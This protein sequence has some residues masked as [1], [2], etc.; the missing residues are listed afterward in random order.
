MNNAGDGD[1]LARGQKSATFAGGFGPGELKPSIAPEEVPSVVD[2]SALFAPKRP[3]VFYRGVP[4]NRRILVTQVELESNSSI[5]IPDS[6]KGHSEV[7]KIKA[8]SD[9]SELR[10][11]GLKVGDLV[12]FDKYAAHGQMFP[13]LNESG[14]TEPTLLLQE[15]DIQM[16]MEAV[17]N[18]PEPIVN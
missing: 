10:T 1:R 5:I 14:E 3:A 16:K 6:A 4:F 17:K 9:D 15:H 11:L 12:L 8:F 2:N 13:L 18:D 7:G